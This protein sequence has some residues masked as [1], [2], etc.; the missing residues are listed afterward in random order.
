MVFTFEQLR[1]K[2]PTL[3]DEAIH[4]AVKLLNQSP[5]PVRDIWAGEDQVGDKPQV[6]GPDGLTTPQRELNAFAE[7]NALPAP[8]P[9]GP[10][11]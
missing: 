1:K 7:E 3:S 6:R 5:A 4:E 8:F 11:R 10:E 9:S 2:Y